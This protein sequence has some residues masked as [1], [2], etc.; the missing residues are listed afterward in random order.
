MGVRGTGST[1]VSTLGKCI[2][3]HT[4]DLY[5]SPKMFKFYIKLK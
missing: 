1:S 3:L 4:Y 2:Q 5:L